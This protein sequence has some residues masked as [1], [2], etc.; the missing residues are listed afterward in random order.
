MIIRNPGAGQGAVTHV[1][2]SGLDLFSP[3]R[4]AIP[5]T[6]ANLTPTAGQLQATC[7][8]VTTGTYTAQR[9]LVLPLSNGQIFIVA[10]LQLG[11]FGVQCIGATGTGVVIAQ[12]KVAIIRCDGT[13]W[14]RVTADT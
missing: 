11:A 10:N 6:D 12:N 7:L 13:N 9:N 8:E 1:H 5:V 4:S 14:V 2:D 3:G